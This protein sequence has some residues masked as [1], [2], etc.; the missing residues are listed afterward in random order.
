MMASTRLLP[1]KV[2]QIIQDHHER[3]DG[4]GYPRG[5]KGSQIDR[6]T[7]IVAIADTYDA[8]TTDQPWRKAMMPQLALTTLLKECGETLDRELVQKFIKCL[9]IY[10]IGSLVRLSTG[11]MAV[12]LSSDEESRL[13][14]MV[15]LV[16]EA[17][18]SSVTPHQIVSLQA[19]ARTRPTDPWLITEMLDP[20]LHG[21][22]VQGVIASQLRG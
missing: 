12:V 14:P 17:D 5:L 8:M 1:P 18:G 3:V 7:L 22:D 11:A 6:S 10:P 4:S 16:R 2:L 19:I 15:L 21:V 20:A 9:G 13:K